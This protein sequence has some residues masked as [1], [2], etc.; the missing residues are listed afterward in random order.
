MGWSLNALLA[1]LMVIL[2]AM[3]KRF[4]EGLHRRFA[5]T[6]SARTRLLRVLLG[7]PCLLIGL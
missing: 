5:K 3:K 1:V 4:A 7:L 2:A 6:F